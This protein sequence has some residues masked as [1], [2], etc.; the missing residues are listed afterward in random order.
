MVLLFQILTG[1]FLVFYYC[2]DR[3]ISFDRVQ[4]IIY[5]SIGGWLVRVMHFNGASLFFIFIYLHIF[6]GLAFF[7]YRLRLVW[8][9]GILMF[10]LFMG[11]AFIGYVL[12]W[13]QMRFWASVVITSLL[14][15]IPIWGFGL[16]FWVWGGFSV[17]G[18]TLKFFFCLHFLLP[19]LGWVF[20]GF[21]LY[22]LHRRGSTSSLFCFLDVDKINFFPYFLVKDL[23]NL[24]IF[25]L[26]FSLSILFPFLLGDPEIFLESNFLVSPIHI[27]PEWYFLFAYAILRCVPNKILGVIFILVRII[28]FLFFC[29]LDYKVGARFVKYYHYLELCYYVYSFK[30]IGSMSNGVSLYY[31]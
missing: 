13:A 31:R 17:G 11:V 26:F 15:V 2:N 27:V 3:S 24:L 5:E 25:F 22:F 23:L 28:S 12:V 30:V 9:V 20:I 1:V 8:L 4:Y 19:W 14:T 18:S 16:V 21:H 6:K 10:F 29:V 7:R